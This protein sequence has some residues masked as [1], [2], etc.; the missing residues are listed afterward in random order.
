MKITF[1]GGAGEVG[2]SC[3]LVQIDGKN[4]LLD[5][6]VRLKS[7]NKDILP[8]FRR[9]QEMGGVDAI[10]LSHAHLDHSGSLP[11]ISREYPLARIYMTHATK[12]LIGVLLWD[13]LKVMNHKEGEIPIYAEAHVRGMME[14]SVC[15]S[16]HFTFK[17]FPDR[18]LSVTFYPAGHIAGAAL[19]YIRGEEGTLLYTGDL[20]L[21]KQQTVNG[22]FIPALRPDV[23]ISEAT[24]GDKLHSNR[25]LEENRL[26]E[27]VKEVICRGGKVL[28]PAFA[29]GRAQEIILILKKAMNKKQL[30]AVKI[31]VDG[32]IKD[33]NRVY[34][35]NP[36]Y[37]RESLAKKALNGNE[38]FYD[39]QVLPVEGQELRE[40]VA[41]AKE[42][43]CVIAGSG[44]LTGGYSPW[45]AER[46]AAGENNFL[47]LTG[48]QDEESPGRQLLN[49]ITEAEKV[50]NLNGKSIPVKCGI[51]LYGLSAHGDKGELQSA[52]HKLAPRK[53]FLVHGD[54]EIIA[55]FAKQ[56]NGELWAEIYAP[57]NGEAYEVKIRNPRKQL[58]R[59]EKIAPLYRKDPLTSDNIPDLWRYLAREDKKG[60]YSLEELADIWSGPGERRSTEM[61][62]I[63]NLLN[64]T[65]YFEPD[66][67]RLFLYRPV[68]EEPPAQ[69]PE[70]M[71]M[72]QMLAF[73]DEIFP[74][75]SGLYKKGARFEER[76]ALLYFKF[77]LRAM[78]L[79]SDL[80]AEFEAK[81]GWKAEVNP[82][83]NIGAVEDMVGP[84]KPAIVAYPGGNRFGFRLSREKVAARCREPGALRLLFL[85]NVIPRKGLHTL[86]TA[87][88]RLPPGDWHLTVAGRL[89]MDPAYMRRVRGTVA[90][91]RWEGQVEFT[92]VLWERE[93]ALCLARSHLL[94]VPSFYE[95]FGIVYL[96][97]MAFGLPALAT[98]K[99]AAQEIITSG[100]DGFLIAP[101]DA[102]T[103]AA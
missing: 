82:E 18:E 87:L 26:V 21:T 16:P 7:G 99:G 35:L 44:M 94:A 42:S 34:R 84:G 50:L 4:I 62:E 15:Y 23:M 47:A 8:D 59:S 55:G 71:E 43:L 25:D 76:K 17:P 60:P 63:R 73:L 2:A 48:Y 28:F 51:G 78:A 98:T 77:P 66:S 38:I 57:V 95:G 69:G 64:H 90:R 41:S 85:G 6:G 27:M 40:A 53:I 96:E 68:A 88:E 36:N 31:Y 93:V 86:L 80:I 45:Y 61:E 89:D 46:I 32:M 9:I 101:G 75:E 100:K 54:G 74:E 37:L 79:Y 5:C 13:S 10:I 92:G 58:S 83:C 72:N 70:V 39:D 56:L 52:I 14:Q 3:Y 102:A 20:S 1:C 30:P 12:A 97:G 11:I 81:S 24:Y 49:L 22:A 19:T 103:L 65:A 33:I 91:R 67:R 29:L